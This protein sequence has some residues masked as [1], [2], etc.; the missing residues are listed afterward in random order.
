MRAADLSL[1]KPGGL[2]TA[3]SIAMELPMVL[4]EVMGGK[5]FRGR[6]LGQ[7]GWNA[8][9]FQREGVAEAVY[10]FQDALSKVE[11][12]LDSP[13]R[14]VAMR[15]AA[16]RLARPKAASAISNVVVTALTDPARVLPDWDATGQAG[17]WDRRIRIP[18]L[19][20]PQPRS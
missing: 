14:L 2:T 1:T 19:R 4:L 3:E 5:P 6:P 8:Q 12:L 18:R 17:I 20:T 15:V 16:S 11:E 13:E 7:E 9:Y 10:D